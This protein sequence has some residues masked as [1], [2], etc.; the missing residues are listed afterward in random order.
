MIVPLFAL[1]NA[2][3][4]IDGDL[5]SDA[6][7]SPVTL[8]IVA[9]YVIGKPARDPRRHVARD[10]RDV[11]RARLTVTWPVLVVAARVGRH[12][13]HGLAA[14]R[15]ARL[16]RAR[17]SRRPSSACCAT[18]IIS[19]A[20]AWV[21]FRVVQRLPADVRARQLG[22]TAETI[23]DLADDVDPERDH[24]RGRPDAP[25]TLLEYGDFECPYCGDAAPIDRQ[26]ARAPATSCATSSATCR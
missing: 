18:A 25:V 1:A 19:P 4:H 17:C 10:P 23:V 9:A 24:I 8:G 12:R 2:G 22:D 16:R 6:I 21:A 3:I 5:L 7:T 20:L 15:H 13:L 26:A 14:G 11:G